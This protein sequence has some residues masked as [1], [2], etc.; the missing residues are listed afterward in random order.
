LLL[1]EGRNHYVGVLTLEEVPQKTFDNWANDNWIIKSK[2][3]EPYY[4][5][6]GG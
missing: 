3:S 2:N 4:V 5:V 1:E 6:D